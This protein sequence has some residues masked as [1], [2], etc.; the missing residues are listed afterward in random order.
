VDNVRGSLRNGMAG[1]L[2]AGELGV[3][4]AIQGGGLLRGKPHYGG[5]IDPEA[6]IVDVQGGGQKA[7]D[8][9]TEYLRTGVWGGNGKGKRYKKLMSAVD[10]LRAQGYSYSPEGGSQWAGGMGPTPAGPPGDMSR[11]FTSPDYEFRRSEG[12]RDIGNS[13]AARGGAA[14]GNALRALTG[15]NSNLAAGEYG[16]YMNRLFNLAGMGQ[17]ATTQAVQTGANTSNALAGLY[18]NQGDARASGVLSGYN[19]AANSI[20]QG[21]NNYLMSKWLNSQKVA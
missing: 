10:E 17:T 3:F 12:Q 21:W 8:L 20:N 2:L 19:A 5:A 16:N 13:F 9:M 11:F 4:G 18:Q 14:S 1:G 15:Y 7:D 6:G